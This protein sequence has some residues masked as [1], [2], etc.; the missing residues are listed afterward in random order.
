MVLSPGTRAPDFTLKKNPNDS[1]SLA[2]L[3]GR[4]AVM[5]FYPADWSPLC[6]D[7]LA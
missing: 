1:M 5:I 6:G 3:K 4:P 2:D 7:E